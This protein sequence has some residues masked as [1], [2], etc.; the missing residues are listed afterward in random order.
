MLEDLQPKK[1][2]EILVGLKVLSRFDVERVME[3]L[4]KRQRKQKFG[5]MARD[6]GLLGEEH[7]LAALA[8]QMHL[9]PGIELMNLRQILYQLQSESSPV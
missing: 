2:G 5:Q 6:M 3:A 7:I 9:L 8:V 4:R 1:I